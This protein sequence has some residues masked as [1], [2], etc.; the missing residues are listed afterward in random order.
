MKKGEI[1]EGIVERVAFPNKGIVR[2][3]EG[4]EVIVKNT[5]PGQTVS[6]S[7]SKIRKGKG[8]GRLLEVVKRLR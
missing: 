6:F 3:S 4:K 8:E 1:L 2:T 7:V 5:V